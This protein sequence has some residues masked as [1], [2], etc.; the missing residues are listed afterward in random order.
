[1]NRIWA[2]L[3][4][5]PTAKKELIGK[6]TLL[7]IRYWIEAFNSSKLKLNEDDMSPQYDEEWF[8]N[9]YAS[10]VFDS[11]REAMT[12]GKDYEGYRIREYHIFDKGKPLTRKIVKTKGI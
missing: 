9:N 8:E 7:K 10:K 6:K 3:A 2:T 1:M 5:T 12:F 4:G 11:V